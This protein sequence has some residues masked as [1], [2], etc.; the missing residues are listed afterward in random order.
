MKDVPNIGQPPGDDA[1][2]D[3]IHVAV[4]PMVATNN[5]VPGQRLRNGIVDPF[6]TD[7]VIL[8]GERFWLFL[9]PGTVTGLRHVWTHPAFADEPELPTKSRS[10]ADVW[11]GV[12]RL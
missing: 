1:K 8:P 12:D 9:Y 6:R 10:E 4:L 7:P 5:L 11:A 3:A 2:R